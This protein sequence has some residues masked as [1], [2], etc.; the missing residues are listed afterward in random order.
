MVHG[1]PSFDTLIIFLPFTPKWQKLKKLSSS[2]CSFHKV[3]PPFHH[4]SFFFSFLLFFLKLLSF[5][6]CCAPH[7]FKL[8]CCSKL[9]LCVSSLQA[10]NIVG[11]CCVHHI[12]EFICFFKLL[13]VIAFAS[14][15][16]THEIVGCCAFFG[17]FPKVVGCRYSFH[18]F[19]FI[20]RFSNFYF[21]CNLNL[22]LV[23]K[24]RACKGVG[25]EWSPGITFHIP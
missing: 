17:V 22:G 16:R 5:L 19:I 21:C 8:L 6:L 23:T 2:Y 1:T 12:F 11:S 7:L 24:A 14:F 25:Q 13:V 18:L 10:R 4:L 20:S 15:L 3:P 9:L